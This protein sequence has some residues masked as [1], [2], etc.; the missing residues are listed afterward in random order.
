M[1]ADG[2]SAVACGAARYVTASMKVGPSPA[3]ARADLRELGDIVICP[4]VLLREGERGLQV[5]R[6]VVATE[7]VEND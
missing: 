6:I 5:Q 3:R 2:S 4:E 1:Y 7:I